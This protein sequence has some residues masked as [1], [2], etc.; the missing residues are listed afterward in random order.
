MKMNGKPPV[1]EGRLIAAGGLALAI[2]QIEQL[3]VSQEGELFAQLGVDV[4]K[5]GL[6]PGGELLHVFERNERAA[7]PAGRPPCPMAEGVSTPSASLCFSWI[8][9]INGTTTF[10]TDS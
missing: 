8:C 6:G 3:V 4:A 2:G 10:S 9:R 5:N 1:F 7:G